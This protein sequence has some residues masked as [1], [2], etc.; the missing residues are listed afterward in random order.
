M[1]QETEQRRLSVIKSMQNIIYSIIYDMYTRENFEYCWRSCFGSHSE[2]S[3]YS[4]FTNV[5]KLARRIQRD[6]HDEVYDECGCN[7]DECG[8]CN[9]A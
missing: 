6:Y 7:D 5:L 3:I 1:P 8:D 9:K 4:I 2:N